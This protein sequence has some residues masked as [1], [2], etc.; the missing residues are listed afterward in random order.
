MPMTYYPQS[1]TMRKYIQLFSI[2]RFD[3]GVDFSA[4]KAKAVPYGAV[5]LIFCFGFQFRYFNNRQEFIVGSHI[6]GPSLKYYHIEHYGKIDLLLVNFKPYGLYL[7]VH[8]PVDKLYGKVLDINEVDPE[9]VKT[10]E[11]LKICPD[12]KERMG[13]LEGEMLRLFNPKRADI[14]DVVE[15]VNL[16]VQKQ[17]LLDI[18]NLLKEIPMSPK[19]LERKFRSITGMTPKNYI[20]LIRFES[21]LKKVRTDQTH[22]NWME[23]ALESGY[24]DQSHFIRDFKEFMGN[25]PEKYLNKRDLLLDIFH[26]F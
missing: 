10:E 16:I 23:V 5:N 8:F 26:P 12:D 15:A 1:E 17:G 19:T 6:K 25:P 22:R 4:F 7:F 18:E 24:Y 3:E 2:T 11:L 14:S 9:F 13:V 20:R 21:V